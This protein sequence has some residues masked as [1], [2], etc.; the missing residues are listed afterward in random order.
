[1]SEE[2]DQLKKQRS[3]IKSNFTKLKNHVKQ[4]LQPQNIA[5]IKDKVQRC[6]EL[7]ASFEDVHAKLLSKLSTEEIDDA[8]TYRANLI[9]DIE[10]FFMTYY[11]VI[12]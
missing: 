1:M 9:A 6:P 11:W 8:R 7:I 5:V 3:T 10:E 4:N 2:I 12:I